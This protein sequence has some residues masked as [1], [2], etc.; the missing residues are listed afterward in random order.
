MTASATGP[1]VRIEGPTARTRSPEGIES[2]LAVEDLVAKLAPRSWVDALVLPDGVKCILPIPRGMIV[3]HQSPPGIYQLDWI[4]HDSPAPFGRGATYAP[5]CI[6]LPYVVVLATFHQDKNG[7]LQLGSGNECFFR[8]RS[9][10]TL[11][12]MLCYPA[13]L[14]CSKFDDPR[15]PLSW[16]CTEKLRRQTFQAEPDL[17]RRVRKSVHALLQ[18]LWDTRFNM[19]SDFHELASWYSET[20]QRGVDPRLASIETWQEASVKDPLFALEVPW[21]ETGLTLRQIAE[22]IGARESRP[23]CTIKDA[24]DLARLVIHHGKS[25]PEKP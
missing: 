19:S 23:P 9:L 21:I 25:H 8:N 16:I 14:N 10:E 3:V 6:A 18:H 5:V 22:R 2:S 13:L 17:N 11:D 15:R 24:A 4:K 20:M 12:D 7:G 1:V